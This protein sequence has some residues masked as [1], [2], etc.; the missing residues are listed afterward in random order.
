MYTPRSAN[1]DRRIR[2]SGRR[3]TV[4]DVYY[5]G[6]VV[7]ENLPVSGGSI[8]VELDSDIRRSGEIT[9]ADPRLVP[10]FANDTLSPLGAEIKVRQGMVYP[11]G[12]EELI[13]LGVFRLDVTNWSD[14]SGA[15]PRVQMFDRSKA[16]QVD[17]GSPHSRSGWWASEV[18]LEFIE[19]FYPSLATPDPNAPGL[20]PTSFAAVF[21]FPGVIDYR[22]P[23]GHIWESGTYW[24]LISE[25]AANMGCQLYFDVHGHPKVRP[26]PVLDQNT[27]ATDAVLTVGVGDDGILV[28]ADHTYSREGVFNS[29]LVV[30][31]TPVNGAAP[32]YQAFNNTPGSPLRWGGPFGR[33]TKRIDDSTLRTAAQCKARA[34][35]E[36]RKYT[37]AAYSIDFTAV[38]NPALDV[39]DII[40]AEYLNDTQEL[41]LV[42]N[43]TIP[44]GSGQFSGSSKGMVLNG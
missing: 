34:D 16:M 32:V 42:S 9:L 30:G 35:V 21:D 13:P 17:I 18:I 44:L 5:D 37:G 2:Q 8:R 43:L 24:E 1:F 6:Q 7:A 39:G 40:L 27:H 26:F 36:L 19:F 3:K 10:T 31:L 29:V 25:L 28:D 11:N 38:P 22:L 33:V 4:V 20:P 15:I 23:G 12:T 14:A 41:H